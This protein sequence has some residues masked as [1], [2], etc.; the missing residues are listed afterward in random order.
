MRSIAVALPTW[1]YSTS[2]SRED[3]G[4]AMHV[5]IS[6]SLVRSINSAPLGGIFARSTWR[7]RRETGRVCIVMQ[8]KHARF[9]YGSA[10]CCVV[11]RVDVRFHTRG[12][13]NLSPVLHVGLT[14]EYGYYR[15]VALRRRRSFIS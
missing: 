8:C 2:T 6:L 13:A 7:N 4:V 3:S 10:K 11:V 9:P 15:E 14:R 12:V 5:V 1:S